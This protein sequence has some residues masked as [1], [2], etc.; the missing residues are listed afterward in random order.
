MKYG[1]IGEKL[2]HSLSPKIYAMLGIDYS[3]LEVK[4]EDFR[5]FII[6]DR[7]DYYN[8]TIPYKQDII[9]YLD[10]ISAEAK[11]INAVNTI[12]RVGGKLY[13]YNTDIVGMRQAI[14]RIGIELKGKNVMILGTGGTSNTA[15]YMAKTAEAN[16]IVK[17]SR[18][19]KINYTN[20]Y[21]LVD[22]EVIIN[23]TPVGMY[24]N[25]D[26]TPIDISR[27][28]RLL[29]VFDAIYNPL[30]TK[31]IIDSEKRNIKC[32]GGLYMLVAQAL[33][34]IAIFNGEFSES[35]TDKIYN[36]LLAEFTNIVLIGMPSCGKTAIGKRIANITNRQFVDTDGL[37]ADRYN[38][39]PEKAIL[40]Y[41]EDAFRDMET[42]VVKSINKG[43]LVV[44]T[45]GGVVMRESN[46]SSLKQNGKLVYIV[47]DLDKLSIYN[48]PL[49]KQSGIEKL[50][51]IRQPLYE[52]YCDITVNNDKDID[53]VT[54][55]VLDKYKKSFGY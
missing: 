30:Q 15:Y 42:E 19:G 20:C 10:Y 45:G 18:T 2:I 14:K 33:A 22:T 1:L 23:T 53:E 46:I 25:N 52:R 38:I 34:S 6:S 47:R 8:V 50:F 49:S 13:G 32:G 29:G 27:F 7:L 55:E 39:T 12:K 41:G 16:S 48:R 17:V 51:E 37:F 36:E 43:N 26:N 4:R 40:T 5:D 35:V 11:E 24:P 9:P 54:G 28:D 21:D 31:L 44:A 3:L